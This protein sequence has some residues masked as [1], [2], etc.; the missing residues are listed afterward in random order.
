MP[1]ILITNDDGITAGGIRELVSIA[2]QYGEVIVVAPDG[3]QSAQGHAITIEQPIFVRKST[4]LGEDIEAYECS[5]TPVDCVKIA[6]SVLLKG[7]VPDLCLSG[8]NHGSNAAIN[9]IY[10]GTMSAAMEASLEGIPSI[11]FSFLNYRAEADFSVC[12]PYVEKLTQFVLDNGMEE[13]SLFNV[14]IP[15]LPANQIQ[16]IR[17]CRQAEARWVE[18]YQAGEDPRGRPYYWLTG[19]FVNEDEREDTDANALQNGYVSLVPSHHDLTNHSAL[20]K[21]QLIESFLQPETAGDSSAP[22]TSGQQLEQF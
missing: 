12:R 21:L 19:K 5:G 11:G 2:R 6:K 1:L 14:N 20:K 10:S 15:D 9:I 13:G 22:P 4:A 17:I 8:I 3:P 7:R 16:G 18:E